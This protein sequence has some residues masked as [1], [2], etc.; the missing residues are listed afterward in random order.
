[1][2]MCKYVVSLQEK[3]DGG[4][5]DGVSERHRNKNHGT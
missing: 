5:S 2:H 4:R 3:K 1:M